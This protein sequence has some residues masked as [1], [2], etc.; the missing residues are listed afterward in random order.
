MP[1][2]NL[3]ASSIAAFKACP[4]R[5]RLGYVERIREISASENQR[6]GLA[7][8]KALEL[9]EQPG[10]KVDDVLTAVCD[11][12]HIIPDWA[13]PTAWA[14]ERE[15]I[16][17]AL[18]GYAWYYQVG[19]EDPYETIATELSFDLPLV[20]PETMR[21]T[22]NFR[23]VGRMDRVIRV[24]ATQNMLVHEYKTTSRLIDSGSTYWNILRKDTQSKC[25]I[26]AARNM[27]DGKDNP[28]L[29][30]YNPDRVDT[31]NCADPGDCGCNEL[32][33]SISG[34]LHDVFHKPSIRPKKLTLADSKKFVESGK[35]CDREFEVVVPDYYPDEPIQVT[36]DGIGAE[37]EPGKKEGTYAIR[38]TPAMFGVRF[39]AD[40]VERPAYYFV[41]KEIPFSD[42]ELLDFRYQ[43]WS[44][45][46]TMAEMERTGYWYENE[47]Q[48]EAVGSFTC[49]YTSLCYNN[50]KCC[51][52][53]TVPNGFK[54]LI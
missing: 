5:Y 15:I 43:L 11:S 32:N 20:N 19:E 27:Q 38:E 46:R 54:R 35:Y 34:L 7:W 29:T 31:C 16:V 25:Y 53:E 21:P 18:V 3:S 12:Y 24:N 50:I 9:L 52:G 42:Q 6:I 37:V 39:L 13:N 48:C 30:Y 17:N 23:R 10:A 45:Q 1:S 4:V 36:V 40:I 26:L 14:V 22:P 28:E 47:S 33:P 44:L 51:D 2:K 8:H 41:R 49:P